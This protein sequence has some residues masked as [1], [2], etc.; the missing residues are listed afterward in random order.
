M[1]TGFQ[2]WKGLW[3]KMQ[4]HHVPVKHGNIKLQK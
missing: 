4:V 1:T 3:N 2:N